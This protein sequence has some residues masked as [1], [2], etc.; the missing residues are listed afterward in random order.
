MDATVTAGVFGLGGAI[1][2]AAGTLF[3]GWLQHRYQ[4]S[5]GKDERAD[6]YARAASES[7]LDELL[8]LQ[9]AVGDV[10]DSWVT[11]NEGPQWRPALAEHLRE[12]EMATYVI[13]NRELRVRLQDMIKVI[14]HRGGR[15]GLDELEHF[16]AVSN[17]GVNAVA[18]YLRGD[19]LPASREWFV[20]EREQ[21]RVEARPDPS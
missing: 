3:G 2:G 11:G 5:R 9:R 8:K 19:P 14:Y 7:V 6:A 20:R 16:I 21:A 15:S 4:A 10:L 18:A 13:P 17:I 1:V 12:V